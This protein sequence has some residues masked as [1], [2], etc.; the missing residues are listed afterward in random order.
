[1]ISFKAFG[2]ASRQVL[3]THEDHVV[4]ME[5]LKPD[6]NGP[7]MYLIDDGKEP[8]WCLRIVREPKLLPPPSTGNSDRG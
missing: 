2:V 3:A 5:Y 8:Q 7:L 6:P 1:V 4:I